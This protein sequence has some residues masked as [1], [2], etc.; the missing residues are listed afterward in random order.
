MKSRK[1]WIAGLPILLWMLA[2]AVIPIIYI[3]VLSFLSRND[4][5]NIIF[6]FSIENYVRIFDPVYLNVFK[7]SFITAVLTS[8]IALI[9]GYPFA[10]FTVKMD[11]KYRPLI[12]MMVIIPFWISSLL[13]LYGWIVLLKN[14]GVLNNILI[15]LGITDKPV[16]LLYNYKTVIGGMVYML[17]P[18][19]ILPI[20][21]S[22]SKLDFKLVE[23]SRDLGATKF[24]TFIKIILPLTLDGIAG[25]FT[26]VF[27]PAMGLFFVSD[28][29]GGAKT[30]LIGNLIQN[31]ML[32]SR[33]WP[34]GSALSV[35]MLLF[36]CFFVFIYLKTLKSSSKI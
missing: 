33:N 31:Q 9:I 36:V 12:I 29:L 18:F 28:L 16:T 13:R 17:L 25:G 7:T 4:S 3:V 1:F 24:T 34:F 21:N 10:Y 6:K 30:M 8:V 20:Y 22:V 26:L 11:L 23:A 19:M 32:A 35:I 27:I 14:D 5:G 2:L 15:S